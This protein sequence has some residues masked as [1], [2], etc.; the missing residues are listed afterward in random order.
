MNVNLEKSTKWLVDYSS[1]KNEVIATYMFGS[2]LRE[3][4]HP[5]DI[6]VAFLVS[7]QNT[8]NSLE[9][10]IEYSTELSQ[11]IHY[12]D[13]DVVILNNAPVIFKYD[14][15]SKGRLIY[16]SDDFKRI[17]FETISYRQYFHFR[18][19][20][21]QYDNSTRKRWT[22]KGGQQM[23]NKEIVFQRANITETSIKKLEKIQELSENEFLSNSQHL[24]LAEHYLRLGIDALIDLSLHIIAVKSLGRPGNPRE[25]INILAQSEVIPHDFVQKG[26]KLVKLR[27]KLIHLY[28]EVEAVDIYQILQKELDTINKFLDY[29][30]LTVEKEVESEE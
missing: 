13:F 8:V 9:K 27:D 6:D 25:I 5:K 1:Q 18:N 10:S 26:I 15:I 2:I 30:L 11:K 24:A 21:E 12:D 7:D 17:E 14:V 3:K 19:C 28:W 29:L 22:N 16:S 20:L 4:K 23:F